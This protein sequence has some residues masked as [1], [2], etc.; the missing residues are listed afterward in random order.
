[1]SFIE[2]TIKGIHDKRS[3][4]TER[5]LMKKR[6]QER[7]AVRGVDKRRLGKRLSHTGR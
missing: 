4:K 7:R 1:M 3:I 2:L 6:C 5:T